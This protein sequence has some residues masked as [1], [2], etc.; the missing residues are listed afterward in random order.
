MPKRKNN[1]R[2]YRRKM[3]GGA[4]RSD[5]EAAAAPGQV[6]AHPTPSKEIKM[7]EGQTPRASVAYSK[8]K[9]AAG[10]AAKYILKGINIEQWLQLSKLFFMIG[11]I[12]YIASS[13]SGSESGMLVSYY[14]IT[15]GVAIM[16]FMTTI[17]VSM[18]KN[19]SGFFAVLQTCL[20]L[21]I[22]A[23]FL[24]FPLIMLIYIFSATAPI[25]SRD[26]ELPSAY[27]KV[28][29]FIFAFIVLQTIF[30]NGFYQSEIKNMKTGQQDSNKWVYVSGLILATI[31]TS[32][33]SAEL[34]VIIT[35]FLT[36]G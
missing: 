36:D 19:V 34:Y 14:W 8:T 18:N 21:I 32:A 31:L 26:A 3:K 29:T 10:K 23:L 20:P 2:S 5:P 7:H 35:S 11:F 33:A 4:G 16:L 24:L 12:I 22:P 15:I 28:S 13:L 6:A 17:M 1:K 27:N 9:K 25:I 30:L